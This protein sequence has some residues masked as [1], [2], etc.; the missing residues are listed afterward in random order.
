MLL[1]WAVVD[2]LLRMTVELR[3]SLVRV[4]CDTDGWW[5]WQESCSVSLCWWCPLHSSWLSLSLTSFCAKT[6]ASEFRRRWDVSLFTVITDLVQCRRSVT[7]WH[8]PL[9]LPS[10]VQQQSLAQRETTTQRQWSTATRWILTACRSSV[11]WSSRTARRAS[12]FGRTVVVGTR[13][14][15]DDVVHQWSPT[16]VGQGRRRCRTPTNSLLTLMNFIHVSGRCWLRSSTGSSSGCS[17]SPVSAH[18]AP[19]S[20]RCRT[21]TSRKHCTLQTMRYCA[22]TYWHRRA[23]IRLTHLIQRT[24]I[25]ANVYILTISLGTQTLHV[26]GVFNKLIKKLTCSQKVTQM[27]SFIVRRYAKCRSWQFCLSIILGHCVKKANHNIN[28]FSFSHTKYCDQIST[29]SPSSWILNAVKMWKMTT[30]PSSMAIHE[31]MHGVVSI[32]LCCEVIDC[33]AYWMLSDI[34]ELELEFVVLGWESSALWSQICYVLCLM[35][36]S[37]NVNQNHYYLG[38]TAYITNQL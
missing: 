18:W 16:V 7:L 1:S 27:Q 26:T 5:R 11:N 4:S 12:S 36:T 24:F 3:C 19:C 8:R 32:E 31:C 6:P 35:A 23:A 14:Q 30:F 33:I 20:P 21:K 34:V 15:H 38:N 29:A 22:Y 25:I 13:R 9:H 28:I 37:A 2:I 10:S 17:S